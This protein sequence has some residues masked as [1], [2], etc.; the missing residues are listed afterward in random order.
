MIDRQTDKAV[1]NIEY[2]ECIYNMV[3][4]TTEVEKVEDVLLEYHR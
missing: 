2:I 1:S 4:N 3:F